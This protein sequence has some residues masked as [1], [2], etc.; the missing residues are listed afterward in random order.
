MIT[1]VGQDVEK[2]GLLYLV[3]EVVKWSML[4]GKTARRF[5]KVLN[6]EFPHDPATPFLGVR[7]KRIEKVSPR[8][9]LSSIIHT[10][11]NAE[12]T[13]RPLG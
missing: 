7:P 2:L 4:Y 10:T 1:S 5:L 3:R 6:I 9:A 12:S 11:P 8:R 13:Q